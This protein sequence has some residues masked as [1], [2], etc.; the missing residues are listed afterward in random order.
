MLDEKENAEQNE[1]EELTTYSISESVKMK[2]AQR[3]KR[4]KEYEDKL[5]VLKEKTDQLKQDLGYEWNT[6]FQEKR[7]YDKQ[8]KFC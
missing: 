3:E 4:N 6:I 5:K 8:L 7:C 1:L 2:R